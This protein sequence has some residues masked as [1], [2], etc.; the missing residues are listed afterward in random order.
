MV[1]HWDR[2][3]WEH[4][5]AS[6]APGLADSLGQIKAPVLIIA[7]ENDQIVPV[8]NSYQLAEDLQNSTLTVLQNCGHVPQEECPVELLVAVDNFLILLLEE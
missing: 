8:E 2:A 1:E 3:L 6:S 7:G 4:T 5:K